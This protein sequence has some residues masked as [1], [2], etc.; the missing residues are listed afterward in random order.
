MPPRAWGASSDAVSAKTG[1][2]PL[3]LPETRIILQIPAAAVKTRLAPA[4][5]SPSG[6]WAFPLRDAWN[7]L[8]ATGLLS[9]MA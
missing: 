3:L 5:V 1:D 9:A 7:G 6:G 8:R 2:M 4:A